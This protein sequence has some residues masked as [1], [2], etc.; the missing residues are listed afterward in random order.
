MYEMTC[1]LS[2]FNIYTWRVERKK[3]I[4]ERAKNQTINLNWTATD[5]WLEVSNRPE[6]SLKT[7]Q[8]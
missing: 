6:K 4:N 3:I 1:W 5:I 2:H 8:L 7:P